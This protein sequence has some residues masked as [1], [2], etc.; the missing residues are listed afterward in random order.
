MFSTPSSYRF[1]MSV[2][3]VDIHEKLK[4]EG[5]LIC[6]QLRILVSV[7]NYPLNSQV[8]TGW[9]LRIESLESLNLK[10]LNI[11]FFYNVY[12]LL[13]VFVSIRLSCLLY[14]WLIA[15]SEIKLYWE[16]VS[17]LNTSVETIYESFFR[18]L[19]RRCEVRVK[20]DL[21]TRKK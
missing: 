20:H 13:N 7:E 6:W 18:I 1:W 11:V 9:L 4:I 5:L 2:S 16:I 14:C 8:A 12:K 17:F 10:K 19:E 3:S 21:G 15:K